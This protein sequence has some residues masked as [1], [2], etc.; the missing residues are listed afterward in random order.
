M[1]AIR[2]YYVRYGNIVGELPFGTVYSRISLPPPMPW[3]DDRVPPAPEDVQV[4]EGPRG[5][6]RV[7]WKI[8]GPAKKRN[9]FV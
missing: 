5:T 2:S 6:R 1:Y 3:K 9:N 8:P 4:T 7:S